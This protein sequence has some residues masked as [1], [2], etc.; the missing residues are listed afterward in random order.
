MFGSV[1]GDVTHNKKKPDFWKHQPSAGDAIS[2]LIVH[3][4]IYALITFKMQLL[5]YD[6]RYVPCFVLLDKYGRAVAKTG[7]PN[8]RLHVIAG[9]SHLLEMKRPQKI[10]HQF[11][12]SDPD[13]N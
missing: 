7:I 2:W 1:F 12:T 9:V 13:N 10:E 4:L 8:S 11:S 5:H 3:L 6:I